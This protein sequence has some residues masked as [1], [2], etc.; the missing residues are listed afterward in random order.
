M[1]KIADFKFA[2]INKLAIYKSSFKELD[3]DC[4]FINE[5]RFSQLKGLNEANEEEEISDKHFASKESL[6]FF[7]KVIKE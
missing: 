7:E 1:K 6:R 3:F 2:S 4:S 5:A